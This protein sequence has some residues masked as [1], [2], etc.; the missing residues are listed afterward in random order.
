MLYHLTSCVTILMLS[1]FERLLK[2][3]FNCT[4]NKVEK[5]PGNVGVCGGG[6]KKSWYW[7]ELYQT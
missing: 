7:C 4:Q 2:A 5:L 6:K 3:S 1:P